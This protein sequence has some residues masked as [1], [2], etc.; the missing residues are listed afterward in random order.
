M[1][2]TLMLT[3][4]LLLN[5]CASMTTALGNKECPSWSGFSGRCVQSVQLT[6]SDDQTISLDA[7]WQSALIDV[8]GKVTVL[9]VNAKILDQTGKEVSNSEGAILNPGVYTATRI[10]TSKDASMHFSISPDSD[11]M[12]LYVHWAGPIK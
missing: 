12:A 1:A 7:L 2:L 6:E 8:T 4:S 10:D 3:L 5:A 9:G 11:H